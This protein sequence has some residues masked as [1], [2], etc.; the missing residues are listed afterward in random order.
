MIYDKEKVADYYQ[1][2]EGYDNDYIL[3]YFCQV[4]PK[5]STVLELGFG[6]GKD[7]LQLKNDYNIQASDYSQ[8]FI[9]AFNQNYDDQVLQVDAIAM[10]VSNTYDCI[11]SSKVL[12]SLQEED[13]IKSLNNQYG[14]LN[15]NGYIFHTLWY[16]NKQED[17]SLIDK[18]LLNQI[19][20]LKYEYIQFIYYKEADF[21]EGEYDSV[22]LIARKITN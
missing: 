13:I 3:N 12:N 19:L 14:V 2:M 10:N 16:G 9:N 21:M 11:Y 15:D 5:G 1:M 18:Q 8:D 20:M 6:T 4:I 22:I 17:D 7:Y